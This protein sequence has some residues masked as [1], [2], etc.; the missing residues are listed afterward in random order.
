MSHEHSV[1]CTAASLRGMA[2]LC[3]GDRTHLVLFG[4]QSSTSDPYLAAIDRSLVSLMILMQVCIR[5]ACSGE[6]ARRVNQQHLPGMVS[7][8][9]GLPH[10]LLCYAK[11]RGLGLMTPDKA[12]C[13]ILNPK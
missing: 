9:A 1:G 10:I 12:A 5:R 8:M 13:P 2:L 11:P 3:M 7:S 4:M 6:S